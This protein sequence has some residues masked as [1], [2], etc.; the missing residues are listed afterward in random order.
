MQPAA[1]FAA[2]IE[3]FTEVEANMAAR[4]APADILV[5]NYFRARRYAGSKDRRFVSDMVYRLIRG[6]GLYCWALERADCA[7]SPR[8]L[9][10]ALLCH[11]DAGSLTLF[12]ADGKFAPKALTDDE[13]RVVA[14]LESLNWSEAPESLA[15]SV[16]DWAEKGLRARFGAAFAD[17]A[18]S[19]LETAPFDIRLN[20]LKSGN[21]DLKSILS[22]ESEL[23]EKSKLSGFS[24]RA[25][26]PVNLLAHQAFKQ[27]CVEIQDEAAQI[28][29]RLIQAGP[30]HQVVDLCAGAGGKSLAMAATMAN[31]G[32][33]HA[34]DIS[35]KRISELAK[36]AQRAGARNIQSALLPS[37]A[38]GRQAR[39]SALK[40][41][42]DRVVLDVPCSGSGTWRR[43]PDQRWRFDSETL[44]DLN[45][46]QDSL[47]SEGAALVKP[48]G[49]LVYMTC[50][51]LSQ[52]NEERAEGFLNTQEQ[53]WRTLDYRD[54]WLESVSRKPVDSLSENPHFLQLAPHSHRTDGFFIA[55]LERTE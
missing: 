22:K 8:A 15:L 48:G 45:T 49:R 29:S 2:V 34:F 27:G 51:L 17:A 25:T 28:A 11:K 1:R 4:N 18:K 19:L 9:V 53:G 42:A 6:W 12:G 14:S 32:Q 10:I 39:L 20:E 31:S 50:S 47:L 55:V 43:N 21:R 33:I 5:G 26:G 41:G 7:K 54:L 38:V 44:Q 40:D 52:E 16:P 24:Y 23:F 35:Q 46:V 13:R 30:G 37:D 36:R 3:L